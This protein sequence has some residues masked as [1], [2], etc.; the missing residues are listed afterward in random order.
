MRIAVS[1]SGSS[2]WIKDRL[3]SAIEHGE[4]DIITKGQLPPERQLMVLF[5]ASRRSVREALKSLQ[6]EGMLYRHQGAGTFVRPTAP[7]SGR[8]ESITNR[9]SPQDIIEVRREIE[10]TLC[11]LAA[12]RATPEDIEMM[13]KLVERGRAAADNSSQYERWDSAFHTKIAES[14]RNMLF[15]GVFELINTVRSEQGWLRTREKSFSVELNQHLSA[16]HLRIVAAIEARDPEAARMAMS[17]HL[18]TASE[19]LV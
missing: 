11:A 2:E 3:R 6:D 13:K 7:K 14:V 4:G 1:G 8:V 12:V 16:Q 9:T 10:P 15:L 5:G 17:Q 18:A 19:R